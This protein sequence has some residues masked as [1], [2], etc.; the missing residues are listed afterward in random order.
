M[1]IADNKV[2]IDIHLYESIIGELQYLREDNRTKSLE[3]EHL[4]RELRDKMEL[5][6]LLLE[7]IN[8]VNKED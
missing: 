4:E 6:R 1:E 2:L 7:K 3:R 8:I 5:I